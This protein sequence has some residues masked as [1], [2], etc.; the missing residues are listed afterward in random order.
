MIGF[1][2]TVTLP[3]VFMI[4]SLGY[5]WWATRDRNTEAK[6]K[7]GS[8]RMD[9]HETRI[10]SLEQTVRA[11]PTRDDMHELRLSIERLNGE[12]RTMAAV[13][14]GNNRIMERIEDVVGRQE[15]HLMKGGK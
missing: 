12:L 5:T 6:F 1:D 11:Q 7:A 13:I 8:E 9:R 4:V 14:E 3:F 15:E 10:N 2:F